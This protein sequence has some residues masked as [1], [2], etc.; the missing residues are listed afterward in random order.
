MRNA[1]IVVFLLVLA[2]CMPTTLNKM[3]EVSIGMSKQQVISAMGSPTETRANEGAE[4]LVYHLR[5]DTD[6][7]R[8]KTPYFVKL[9]NGQVTSYGA[10]GDFNS[11]KEDTIVIKNR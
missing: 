8:A 7:R 3:N 11:T 6:V 4:F 10:M 2:G 5:T 9:E 1:V